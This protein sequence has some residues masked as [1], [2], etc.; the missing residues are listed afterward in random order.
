MWNE[1]I[2][3]LGLVTALVTSAGCN[4]HPLKSVELKS[5]QEKGG[6][7]AVS[8]NRDVDI[9]FVIDNSR[10]MAEEQATLARNFGPLIERLEQDDVRANYRIAV[11]TTDNGFYG[12]LCR[13]N[14][15]G[16]F[17]VS[18]CLQR[19]EDFFNSVTEQSVFD[20][21]CASICKHEDIE[22]LPTT[23]FRDATPSPRPWIESIGGRT[24]LPEGISPVEA[25]QCFAPQGITG[26]GFEAPLESMRRGLLQAGDERSEEYDFMR[27]G[28]IL[29]VVFVTDEADCS[30]RYADVTDPWDWN[31]G[32]RA[33]WSEENRASGKLTSEVCWFAGVE[34]EEQPDGTKECWSADKR[35]DG[36]EAA[37]E[38]E[39]V[40]HPLDRYMEF[41]GEIEAAKKE[42]NPDQELLVAVLTGVPT[43]YDGGPIHYS[44]GTDPGYLLETGIG[45][46]CTS[47]NGEAAPPVRMA[48]IAQAF[49]TAEGDNNLYSVCKQDYSDAMSSIADAIGKQVR[50]PCVET[51]VADIDPVAEG[52][53]HNCQLEE[54]FVTAQGETVK[55][56]V[57]ACLPLD[58]GGFKLPEG[59]D[60]CYRALTDAEGRTASTDDDMSE[61]CVDE[62]WNLELAIERR[63]G[64]DAPSGSR[65]QAR[66]SVSRLAA[67]DCPGL[68]TE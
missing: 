7:V 63:D 62:G 18:S 68:G 11:T 51:C 15:N 39:A 58:G 55:T 8:I 27:P 6:N 19:E 53:Q 21:A 42:I 14:D 64:V 13:S 65:V 41:L 29:A 66:C 45:A 24:N 37:S 23:T 52:L 17:K 31:D 47:E 26:C 48:E 38:D 43:D 32:S 28:A 40:L 30:A 4:A 61:Q 67:V 59:V 35:A 57:P 56:A 33:L 1:Q 2:G 5:E 20:E 10:S 60:A 3:R 54:E 25:F 44:D 36:S 46:G 16:N 22:I 50:P 9:L 12:G 34:C 49:T